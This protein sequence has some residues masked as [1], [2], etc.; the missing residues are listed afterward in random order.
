MV[1]TGN[2]GYITKF[3]L[4]A[5]GLHKDFTL[6]SFEINILTSISSTI[7]RINRA[8]ISSLTSETVTHPTYSNE[9]VTYILNPEDVHISDVY[10]QVQEQSFSMVENNTMQ[11]SPDLPWSSS[12]NT[13]IS[14]K[15]DNYYDNSIPFWI[16]IN[17]KTGLLYVEAPS[18]T[19]DT[20]YYFY[21]D[22][23]ISGS[24]VQKLIKLSVLKWSVDNWNKWLSANKLVWEEWD[25]GYKLISNTCKSTDISRETNAIKKTTQAVT[26][27]LAFLV[28]ASG[29]AF[30]SSFS[31]I[32]LMIYH[33]QILLMLL[34]IGAFIP[35]DIIQVIT[36]IDYFW[37]PFYYISANNLKGFKSIIDNF[38]FELSNNMY[39]YFKIESDSTIYNTC[40]FIFSLILIGILHLIITIIIKKLIIRW[41]SEGKWSKL[42]KF[43]I[44]I[45]TK[46]FNFLTFGYYIRLVMEMNQ[47]FLVS[48]IY[49]INLFNISKPLRVVS[50]SFAW[51]VLTLC[52]CLVLIILLLSFSFDRVENNEHKKLGEFFVGIRPQRIAKL[53]IFML[54]M[55][56]AV[57]FWE[58]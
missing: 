7:S 18:V 25:S 36:G 26:A 55:R 11:I 28:V 44:C 51:V 20:T 27:L 5:I 4:E 10:F 40:S 6:S 47:F 46:I 52:I 42:V 15:I 19:L 33:A 50:L 2:N 45:S 56:R 58:S 8:S 21:V 22:S 54:F 17:S 16:K 57:F 31:C 37:N 23:I 3:F 39:E 38:K 49:E 1:I 32:W 35:N 14:F 29:I 30:P 12:Q 53:H 13:Q 48:S 34:L 43:M 41:N 9:S 24:S